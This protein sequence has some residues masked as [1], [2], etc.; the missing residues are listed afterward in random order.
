M[1][2]LL[3]AAFCCWRVRLSCVAQ[4]GGVGSGPCLETLV[5]GSSLR[6]GARFCSGTRWGESGEILET[7]LSASP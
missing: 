4:V 1:A 5:L 3:R 2:A 7:I 6:D